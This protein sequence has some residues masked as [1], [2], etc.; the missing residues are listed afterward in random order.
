MCNAR[1]TIIPIFSLL[2]LFKVSL[3][4]GS[5][6]FQFD[7]VLEDL[8]FNAKYDQAITIAEQEISQSTDPRVKM[9]LLLRSSEIFIYKN[10]TEKATEILKDV[11][12]KMNYTLKTDEEINFLYF[13]DMAMVLRESGK[14]AEAVQW[15]KKSEIC[16]KKVKNPYQTDAA[17]LYL[18]LGKSSYETRDSIN[19]IRYFSKSIKV[20][21]GNSLPEK[22]AKLTG[23]SYLQLA[24]LFAQKPEKAAQTEEKTDSAFQATIN[25]NH[26]SLFNFYLNLSFI[27]LNYNFNIQKAEKALFF[28]SE[29]ANN[30]CSPSNPKYGL[31]YCYKAQLAYQEHDSEKALGYFR[32]AE[33]YLLK[34]KDLIPYMYLFYFD[35]ANTYYFYVN[36]FQKAIL[37]YRKVIENTNPWLKRAHIN[38]LVLSGYCY[39]ELGDTLMAISS[40]RNGVKAAETGFLV[41][42]REKIY[43]YRCLAGFYLNIGREEMAYRYFQKAYEKSKIY[44]VGWDLETDIITNLANYHRDKGDIQKALSLYQTAINKAFF[45]TSFFAVG[46]A[47]C[48]EIEL[49]EILNNKGYAL[50]QLY[51]KEDKNIQHLKDALICQKIAIRLIERRL[52]YLDNESSEYNW[53]AVVQTTFNNAVHYSTLLYNLTRDINYAETGFQSAEKS[54]MMII[55]MAS[56]NK[57][58]KK[59]T[60][61]PD[62]LVQKEIRLH[63]DILNLQNQLYRS[64]RLNSISADQKSISATLAKLQL[65]NDELKSLYETN[66]TRYFQLKYNQNVISLHSIQE[67]LSNNQILIEYQLLEK[68]LVIIAIAKDHIT[69]KLLPDNDCDKQTINRFYNSIAQSP[70]NKDQEKCFR[71]FTENSYI[72][73]S[74]LLRPIEKEIE[75]KRLIIIPHNELSLI[76]FEMLISEL[77]KVGS[78]EGYKSLS[79]LI[80]NHSV[81]YG[82]SGTLLFEETKINPRK[83]AAFFVPNYLNVKYNSNQN[84]LLNLIGAQKEVSEANKLI[85]GDLFSGNRASETRFKQNAGKYRILHIASHAI[86]DE[87]IPSLSSL[88]LTPEKDQINDGILYSYELCQLHL[89]AQMIVLSGCNTGMGPLKQGEGLL[90]LSRSFF[91]SGSRTVAFTLWPQADHAGA[92]IMIGFYNGIKNKMRLEDALQSAKLEYLSSADPAKSHPY[93]WGAFLIS[94]KTDPIMLNHDFPWI[95]IILI[96]ALTGIGAFIYR[97]I[98]S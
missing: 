67:N 29:I 60:G 89:N 74:W 44:D 69:M 76:P 80:R 5:S 30:Y 35:L 22:M 36:D 19:A 61:V 58:M 64:E 42:D 77:P 63:N 24:Y 56:R 59:F 45:D 95:A 27:Y 8:I 3:L 1:S 46:N 16:L 7:P 96:L 88:E 33:T 97:K 2:F 34:N 39:L 75:N 43:P 15:M 78:F 66:Y 91:F 52:G 62:S 32:Q 14:N 72:L 41:S 79:Y 82:Y 21:S 28:A 92:E 98:I 13:L 37:N 54:R 38:S 49:M 73:Y 18:L 93:Y 6:P 87:E 71:E 17:R 94:G 4:F 55:L 48:D 81:C 70:H 20:L 65:E 23:L 85:G 86:I 83:S 11:S 31:L 68:E 25:K 84:L 40:I 51:E 10:N 53:L 9:L 12:V 90:S 50:L 26:P 57:K 47:F